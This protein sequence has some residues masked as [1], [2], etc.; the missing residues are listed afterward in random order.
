VTVQDGRHPGRPIRIPR[1]DP[2]AD[3]PFRLI[4]EV[5][6]RGQVRRVQDCASA[7][8]EHIHEIPSDWKKEETAYSLCRGTV[9][10]PVGEELDAYC[11]RWPD[12]T[13]GGRWI[14]SY[15]PEE[16]NRN[17]HKHML[18]WVENVTEPSSI[19]VVRQYGERNAHYREQRCMQE[20]LQGVPALSQGDEFLCFSRH[21]V[22]GN[23]T[24]SR[25]SEGILGRAK[26]PWE[27]GESWYWVPACLSLLRNPGTWSLPRTDGYIGSR[28][29]RR[30]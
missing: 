3:C 24:V 8:H 20:A 2:R 15:G 18:L 5:I 27:F 7:R 13:P 22:A 11:Q 12:L 1:P 28:S 9:S 26:V 19:V 30:A 29:S 23:C 25:K 14:Y 6:V 16:R 21:T 4:V 17:A 10:D